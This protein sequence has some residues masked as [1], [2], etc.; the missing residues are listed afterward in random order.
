MKT[1]DKWPWKHWEYTVNKISGG[2]GLTVQC[3]TFFCRIKISSSSPTCFYISFLAI[4]TTASNKCENVVCLNYLGS[5][6]AQAINVQVNILPS[7][8]GLFNFIF[9]LSKKWQL[10]DMR[11]IGAWDKCVGFQFLLPCCSKKHFHYSIWPC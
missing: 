9:N 11:R 4:Q 7:S 1:A 10:P 3:K 6:L 5:F 2:D 8:M